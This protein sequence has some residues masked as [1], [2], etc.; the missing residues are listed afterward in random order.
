MITHESSY[1]LWLE[2][3]GVGSKDRVSSSPNSYVSY[4][5]TVAR[6]IDREISPEILFDER[7]VR[8]IMAQLEGHIAPNTIRNCGSAMRQYVAMVE[9]HAHP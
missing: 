4:L 9:A 8:R 3:R 6:L 1:R 7:G 2:R 5:R